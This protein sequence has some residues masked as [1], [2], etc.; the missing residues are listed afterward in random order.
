MEIV[1]I[2]GG[3]MGQALAGVLRQAKDAAVHVWDIRPEV[4]DAQSKEE[5]MA[6]AEAMFLCIPSAAVRETMQAI[7]QHHK[8]QPIVI[9]LAKGIEEGSLKT[10]DEIVGETQDASH[11]ALLGGPMLAEEIV[12]GQ[13]AVGVLAANKE[14]FDRLQ[15]LFAGSNIRL[16]YAADVHSVALAGVLKN[17]YTLIIAC[18]AALRLGDNYNGWLL[19][20]SCQEMAGIMQ[21]L[22]ADGAAAYA[23]AGLGDLIATSSSPYSKNHQAGIEIAKLGESSITSEGLRS[24]PRMISLLGDKADQFPVLKALENIIINKASAQKELRELLGKA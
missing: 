18:A 1:I 14:T 9:S 16:E 8:Q 6:A 10:M 2:G 7:A 24:L 17:I 20:L 22:G 21:A 3:E 19:A 12:L 15:P 23:A 5:L 13:P 4:S 11:V